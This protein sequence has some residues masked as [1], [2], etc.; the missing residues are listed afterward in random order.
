MPHLKIAGATVNQTPLDWKGNFNRLIAAIEDAQHQQVDIL[1]FPELSITGY[2]S[3]DLFLSYWY[4]E[5]ALAYVHKLIPYCQNI[6]VCVGTPVR[7]NDKVYN[8][9]AVIEN[10]YLK[11]LVAKQFMAIDG[12]H[13]EFRWF[14]PWQHGE[15]KTIEFFDEDVPLGDIIFEKKG[16]KYG[17]EICED[18]WR[19]GMRPGY[20]LKDRKVDLIFNPSA[21][22]FALGKTAMREELAKSSSKELDAVYCYTNLLGNESGRMIFDGE[23]MVAKNGKL[24]EKNNLLSFKDHQLLC[25]KFHE[26]IT[27]SIKK[28]QKQI[29]EEEF[30]QAVSLALFDYMRKSRS[31][32]FVL[33]LSGGAD[34]SSVAILVSEMVRR[35]LAELGTDEFLKKINFKGELKTDNPQKE[36]VGHLLTCAYQ[37][38]DNSGGDTFK[39]AKNLAESI[40]ATFYDWQIGEEVKGF[41]SKIEKAIGRELT[42]ERD[43]ITLQNIQARTRSPI[44]WMLA[45]LNNA[46]LLATSNRNEGSVGYTTMDGDTSGSISPIAAIDKPFIINWL[47]WAEKVLGYKG[48][49]YVNSLQPTAEL[50]PQDNKQTDEEDLM[51]YAVMLEI[52]KLALRD[53]RSPSDVYLNLKEELDIEPKKLKDYITKFFRLWSRNQW[54]R[55]RLA[56]AFH[57]DDYNVDPKTWLRFPILSGGFEEELAELASLEEE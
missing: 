28:I 57:L 44:I 21:S 46:L 50:R 48:L 15:I 18:A 9:M 53:H 35:G 1:C 56:P 31:N 45:N 33:S 41:T 6:T 8:C 37:A 51:P 36:L 47:K 7:I 17:F 3:E 23:I 16:I 54:K 4:P 52:E 2:G 24:V 55:E 30:A 25:F 49:Q 42:W 19:G 12:V 11:G 13:Y 32:G 20:R 10:G 22:H 43:D 29:K 39:S 5:R 38:S 26:E 40:G 27:A 14:T 34:S